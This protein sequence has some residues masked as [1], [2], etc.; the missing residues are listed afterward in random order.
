MLENLVIRGRDYKCAVRTLLYSLSEAD[1]EILRDNLV[2]FNVSPN[3]LSKALL[4]LGVKIADS[5]ISRHRAGE[6]SCSRI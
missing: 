1:Q 5:T 2:D 6:C 3:A 4:E